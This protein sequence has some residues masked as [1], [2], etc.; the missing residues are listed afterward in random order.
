MNHATAVTFFLLSLFLGG[1]STLAEPMPK[2]AGTMNNQRL[3]AIIH[4][5][6]GH[7]QGKPGFWRFSI[8]GKAIT[9]ITDEKADRMRILV[10]VVKANTLKEDELYRLMQANFD[11]S[12]DARYAVAQGILWSAFIHP[13]AILSKREFLS[14]LGQTVNLALSFRHGYSSGALIFRGGDSEGLRRRKLIDRL[15]EEGSVI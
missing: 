13:L 6:D 15:L 2:K 5:L 14:G 1:R 4:R 8:E 11:T 10:P 9:I 12:L 7:A 3:G